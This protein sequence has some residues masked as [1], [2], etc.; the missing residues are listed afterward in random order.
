MM[1]QI[2]TVLFLSIISFS[3]A[4]TEKINQMSNGNKDGK[5]VLYLDALG[6]KVDSSKAVYCRYTYYDNGIHIH[7]MGNL[8]SKGGKIE[9]KENSSVTIGK[10]KLLDGEYKCYGKSG[11]LEYIHVFK[12]GEYV[13][14][15]EFFETG[16]LSTF[17][18]YEKHCPGQPHSW[19]MYT[20]DKRGK[21]TYEGP[22][23]KDAQGNWPKMRG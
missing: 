7:P 10:A 15:K 11:R 2:I 1:R 13:L 17:F 22:T 14:Y 3:F 20:Y 4:Q 21:I 23:C 16:E 12:N 5:W 6:G 9:A 8:I 19:Y 18:D